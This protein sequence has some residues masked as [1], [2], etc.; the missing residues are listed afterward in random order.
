MST[1]TL[2]ENSSCHHMNSEDKCGKRHIVHTHCDTVYDSGQLVLESAVREG[3][4]L[5]ARRLAY[6]SWVGVAA[7]HS[8]ALWQ[9]GT[10]RFCF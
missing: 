3:M 5:R 10:Q 1:K 2:A 6:L 7:V 9:T 8:P 4:K